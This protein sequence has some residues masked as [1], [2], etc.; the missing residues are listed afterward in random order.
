MSASLAWFND[1]L[2]EAAHEKLEINE[3]ESAE[4]FGMVIS[5]SQ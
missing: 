4:L 1:S 5:R 3:Q 2:I